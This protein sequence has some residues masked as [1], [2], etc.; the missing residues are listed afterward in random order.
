M[1]HKYSGVRSAAIYSCL[2]D[3][4]AAIVPLPGCCISFCCRADIEL[5]S[6]MLLENVS[7][8]KGF[9]REWRRCAY[10]KSPQQEPK[11]TRTRARTGNLPTTGSTNITTARQQQET[12]PYRTAR[13][14]RQP[15][16]NLKLARHHFSRTANV[17]SSTRS[18]L[19]KRK[20]CCGIFWIELSD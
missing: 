13:I 15:T 14:W 8:N 4:R 3:C 20:C 6:R 5:L 7:H 11:M 10:T 19:H 18:L 1:G 9:A 17:K 12:N 16:R 2:P